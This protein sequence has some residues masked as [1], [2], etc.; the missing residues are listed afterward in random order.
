MILEMKWSKE[1]KRDRKFDQE[2]NNG[3]WIKFHFNLQNFGVNPLLRSISV[4]ESP[5]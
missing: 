5:F 2:S 4:S 1:T 3:S